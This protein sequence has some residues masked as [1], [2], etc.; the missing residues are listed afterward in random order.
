MTRKTKRDLKT[1]LEAVKEER[2]DRHS[3][4]VFTTEDGRYVDRDGNPVE[5]LTG[6]RFVIPPGV[7]QTWEGFQIN[8]QED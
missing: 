1:E 5:E 3:Q 7:W 8:D 2:S 6:I 4:I